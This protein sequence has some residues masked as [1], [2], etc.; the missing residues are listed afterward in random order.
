MKRSSKH[1]HVEIESAS[2]GDRRNA[3]GGGLAKLGLWGLR[4]LRNEKRP[5]KRPK[6]VEDMKG[7]ADETDHSRAG[8]NAQIREGQSLENK[9]AP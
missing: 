5:I 8:M 3:K 7:P 2:R 1:L 4:T 9:H 6:S